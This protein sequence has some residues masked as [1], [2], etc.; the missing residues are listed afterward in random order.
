M[1]D[2]ALAQLAED[3]V[4][5]RLEVVPALAA[6]LRGYRW[7]AVFEVNVP[8]AICEALACQPGDILRF[9]AE[10]ARAKKQKAS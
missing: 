9:E 2:V 6:C 3:A 4:C 1:A 8:D 7:I 5:Q 10:G